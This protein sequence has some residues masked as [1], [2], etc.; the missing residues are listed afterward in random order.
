MSRPRIRCLAAQQHLPADSEDRV[1]ADVGAVAGRGAGH[2]LA[3]GVRSW[4]LGPDTLA[5][6]LHGWSSLRGCSGRNRDG[7]ERRGLMAASSADDPLVVC[8]GCRAVGRHG[9][10]VVAVLELLQQS[11]IGEQVVAAV[12]VLLR[13][14]VCGRF[15]LRSRRLS[16][17]GRAQLHE[18]SRRAWRLPPVSYV[19]LG[20]AREGACEC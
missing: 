15:G 4:W 20:R 9:Y 12:R 17:L 3:P 18:E 6:G 5:P 7:R 16:P 13:V 10:V 8:G 11:G 1:D 2:G 14:R 19:C